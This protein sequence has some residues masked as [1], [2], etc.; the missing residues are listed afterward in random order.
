MLNLSICS[1]LL[2]SNQIKPPQS[3][4]VVA[5]WEVIALLLSLVFSGYILYKM[6]LKRIKDR[7]LVLG[8]KVDQRTHEIQSQK[9]ALEKKSEE[10]KH[11]YEEIQ[12]KNQAIEEAFH[13]LSESFA[14]MSDLNREKDGM[15]SVVAHDLRTPLNNIEGLIQLLKLD[16][17]LN[18]EQEEYVTKIREVVK[19]GNEMIRDL[20]DIN[21]AQNKD[22]V[23]DVTEFSLSNYLDDWKCNFEKQLTEK[24]QKLMVSGDFGDIN[25]ATDQ[26]MLSRILDNLMSNAI[27]FSETNTSIYLGIN[28]VEDHVCISL[29]DEGPGISEKDQKKMFKPFTKLAARPTNGEP[30]NGLGLSIIKALVQKLK[31]TLKVE[32]E[33]SKGT[34]FFVSLP[35]TQAIKS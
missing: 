23:L 33:L 25:I 19:R 10:L 30:S 28:L 8:R 17:T 22:V 35:A 13:H 29:R 14:K 24:E 18:P 6:I 21:K 2:I 32:S 3:G 12:T 7:E 34:T 20:L 5:A 1:I 4:D 15:M 27:K 9:E 31:G 26:G 11:A 16:G